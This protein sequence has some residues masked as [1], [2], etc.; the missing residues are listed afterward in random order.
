[1]T[2][3]YAADKVRY[4]IK[5]TGAQP[6]HLL[7]GA[8][9][10][11][12]LRAKDGALLVLHGVNAPEPGEDYHMVE[13]PK[14]RALAPGESFERSVALVPL[15][16]RDHFEADREPTALHGAVTLRCQAGW[17]ETPIGDAEKKK[18]SIEKLLKWQKLAESAPLSITLP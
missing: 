14:T 13:I 5:N 3:S 2:C 15:R 8:R 11:Y 10:P 16:L 12:L 4:A 18:L 17:G 9:M 7:D 6:V 1:V